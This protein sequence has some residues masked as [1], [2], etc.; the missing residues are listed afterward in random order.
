MHNLCEIDYEKYIKNGGKKE[1]YELLDSKYYETLILYPEIKIFSDNINL[2]MEELNNTT[3]K[4]NT[5]MESELD[6]IPI[7]GFKKFSKLSVFFPILKSIVE[8]NKYIELITFSK[9]KKNTFLKPHQDYDLVCNN[10][11]RTHLG[12]KVPEK[13]GLWVEGEKKSIET[14]QLISFDSSKTHSAFNLSNEERICLIIDIERPSFIKYGNSK[15][16]VTEAYLN[17][18]NES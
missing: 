6:I 14:G 18:V 10:T 5:S 13:C 7:Y 3:C 9:M 16:H 2:I 11:I 4:W 15:N 17:Y 8:N 12:L 1:K